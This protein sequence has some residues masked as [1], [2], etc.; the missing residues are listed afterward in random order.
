MGSGAVG[1]GSDLS[2]C[3]VLFIDASEADNLPFL[4][5]RLKGS[6][7][8]TVGDKRGL[9]RTGCGDQ[10]LPGTEQGAL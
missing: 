8:L 9:C 3:Q 5:D 7:V 2:N 1:K 10:F 6:P 4:L